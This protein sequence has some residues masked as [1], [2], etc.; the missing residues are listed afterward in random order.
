LLFGGLHS[1]VSTATA[2]MQSLPTAEPQP[3]DHLMTAFA[4]FFALLSI[5]CAVMAK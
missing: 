2:F 3:T 1:K 5:A 4:G